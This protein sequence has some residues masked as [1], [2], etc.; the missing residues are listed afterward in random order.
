MVSTSTLP[1][2]GTSE[3]SAIPTA[4]SPSPPKRR[5]QPRAEMRAKANMLLAWT[6][7]S[8]LLMQANFHH[9]R[10]R[11]TLRHSRGRLRRATIGPHATKPFPGVILS[12]A[13]EENPQP[14][15]DR[16]G[17]EISRECLRSKCGF[18]EFS[19]LECSSKSIV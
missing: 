18:R 10:H 4:I 11:D 8:F 1:G 14:V 2:M 7:I 6:Q 19:P 5:N 12:G 9:K 16:R 15:T 17:V 13:P 3:A